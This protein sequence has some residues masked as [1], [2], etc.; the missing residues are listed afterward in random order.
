MIYPAAPPFPPK[1]ETRHLGTFLLC[2]HN[3]NV[4][5]CRKMKLNIRLPLGSVCSV[6]QLRGLVKPRN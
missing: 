6:E 1:T 5:K 2:R 4:P 3:R